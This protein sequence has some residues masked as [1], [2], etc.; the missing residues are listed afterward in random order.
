M[1]KVYTAFEFPKMEPTPSGSEYVQ[2][3]DYDI[4]DG[5]KTLVKKGL[6]NVYKMIQAEQPGV[7]IETII[8]RAKNGDMSVFNNQGYYADVTEMP[9]NPGEALKMVQNLQNYFNSLPIEERAKYDYSPEKFITEYKGITNEP[10]KNT[11]EPT[12]NGDVG[13][14]PTKS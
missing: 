9:T 3:Y 1:T 14:E 5:K 13:T 12:T 4:V 7:Q 6:K 11:N 8:Q 2:E 10:T